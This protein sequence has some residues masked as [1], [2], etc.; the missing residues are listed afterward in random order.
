M[1]PDDAYSGAYN[2]CKQIKCVN[3][4]KLQIEM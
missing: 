4:G 1:G 3:G 2:F